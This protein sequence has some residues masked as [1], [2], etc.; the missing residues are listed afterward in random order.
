LPP[1]AALVASGGLGIAKV[2]STIAAACGDLSSCSSDDVS[3]AA[4][5]GATVWLKSFLGGQV[6]LIKPG[7]TTAAGSG[8]TFRFDT[9]LDA[10][11]VTVAAVVGVRTPAARLYG[12]VGTNHHQATLL[13]TQTISDVTAGTGDAAVTTPGGTQSFEHGPTAG[14]G[15][16][17]EVSSVAGATG[18]VHGSCSARD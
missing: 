7:Q 18:R 6:T 16:S 10:Q 14:T 13:T 3:G 5:V 11:L 1:S 15:C 8:D 17:A 12:L 2:G 4:L 9:T